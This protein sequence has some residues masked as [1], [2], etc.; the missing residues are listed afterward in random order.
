MSDRLK[1]WPPWLRDVDAAM[2]VHAQT[3]VW[4]H[5]RDVVLVPEDSGPQLVPP[6]EA[7]WRVLQKSDFSALIVH[8]PVDG[9]WVHQGGD[10]LAAQAVL[11]RPVVEDARGS[12]RAALLDTVVRLSRARRRIA[13]VVEDASRLGGDPEQPTEEERLFWVAVERAARTAVPAFIPD[14]DRPAVYPLVVWFLDA[15]SDVPSWLLRRNEAIRTVP[16]APP[17]RGDRLVTAQ[18]LFS[19]PEHA[20]LPPAEAERAIEVFASLSEGLS[21]SAMMDVSRIAADLSLP[22]T[23]IGDAIRAYQLGVVESPWR[24]DDLRQ[25]VATGERDIGSRVRGQHQ[26]VTKTLDLLKR[27]VVG[28][29]G[30][31]ARGH[32]TRPRGVLFFAGPTGVGKTELAK[33]ITELVFG[34]E[35]AYLRFDMSEYSSE[36]SEARLIGAP[37]GYVG[38]DA[39]GQLTDGVRRRPF[40]LVLFDEI[41]KA[42]PRILDKFLQVLE[43]GRLTDG[44]G[45]TVHFSETILVFTSNLGIYRDLAGGT[46]EPNVTPDLPY[47]EVDARVRKAV[48]EHFTYR[49]NRPELLNRLGDNI[50]VFGF[51]DQKTAVEL[52]DLYLENVVDRV[53]RE[54]EAR[55]VLQ[56]GAQAALRDWATSD[57]SLGGRGIGAVL[58]SHFVNPLARYVFAAGDLRGSNIVVEDVHRHSGVTTLVVTP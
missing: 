11:G 43:D 22:A 54:H 1:G 56:P 46:R 40:S 9:Q 38:H 28:L 2:A 26:A 55:L 16:V 45:M 53:L 30:A 47:D 35:R 7:L 13:L 21:L 41:E 58:E 14:A 39:G 37:P 23:E 33:A 25:R 27:S 44:R 4:G 48:G 3:V 31:Q 18:R 36:H 5:I 29:T 24:R 8:H 10:V 34:D 49:L 15:E 19:G 6:L 12:D 57:L 52:V 17:D 32:S 42:H 51:I 50:V 20:A